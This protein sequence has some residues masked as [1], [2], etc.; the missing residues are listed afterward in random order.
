MIENG[1]FSMNID[2]KSGTSYTKEGTQNLH[3]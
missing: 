2:Q 1:K 3:I